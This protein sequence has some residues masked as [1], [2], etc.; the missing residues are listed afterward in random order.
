MVHPCMA[1]YVRMDN[2]YTDFNMDPRP[3]I[4][5]KGKPEWTTLYNHLLQVSEAADCFAN[6][7]GMNRRLARLGGLLHDV[8]KAHPDFQKRLNGVR[9]DYTYRHE[10]ASLFFL[11]L[12]DRTDWKPLTEMIIAHHK[13][14]ENDV[15]E[16]G[17][18][19]LLNVEDEGVRDRHLGEWDNWHQIGLEVLEAHGIVVRR[20]EVKEA[21]EAFDWVVQYSEEV[22]LQD[23]FN[24]WR[25]LLMGADHFASALLDETLSILPKMFKRP[26]LR[27]FE[28]K[29]KRFPLS[30]KAANSL[31]PHTMVVASTGAGKTDYLFRRC[32]G[33]VFY[34]LP[35][36]ASINAM[37]Y[38]LKD[39]LQRDNQDLELRMKHAASKL[40]A[41]S[42][43]DRSKK[44]DESI[45]S[46]FGASVKVLTP[47]QVA[48]I[49]L[50][51]K[52]YEAILLD[53]RNCDVILDEVHTYNDKA[54]GI[55]LKLIE[56]LVS[57]NCRI[58]IGTATMPTTL[59]SAIREQL[60]PERT[61]EVRL[62]PD[63]LDQYNRH[64]VIKDPN[65]CVDS[66]D[67]LRA[68]SYLEQ[69]EVATAMA[70][71][72]KVLFI[73]NQVRHAQD[74]YREVKNKY[75]GVPSLLLHSRFKRGDRAKLESKLLGLDYEGNETGTFNTSTDACIVV[76]TQV[77]E[78]SIDISFDV[79]V[80]ACAPLD[81]LIQRFGRI[82]RK[83]LFKRRPVIVL[84]PPENDGPALP[85]ELD[86]LRQ[87]YT[88]L[89]DG[90]LHEQDLQGLLDT[91][92][93]D[94]VLYNINEISPYKDGKWTIG[95]LINQNER[96]VDFLE[97]DSATCI[98]DSDIKEYRE[99]RGSD[100]MP[101][102]FS[103]RY[104]TVQ[105]CPR[106]EYGSE[107][108]VIAAAA[109]DSEMGVDTALIHEIENCL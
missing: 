87:T 52:G 38:R 76:S 62:S 101:L 88:N 64:T 47:F 5:A 54:Q 16:K 83:R 6:Y 55:V 61:L 79:M 103:L 33:R 12:F 50:A 109:Y 92:Y 8:G 45:Q 69:A 26:N 60:E 4:K 70:A 77:V 1:V 9:L 7:L 100:R 34:M 71:G 67:N 91:V 30:L 53:M 3:D 74:L 29:S 39:F 23:G 35:F 58:H 48:A 15:R 105:D 86:V 20:I 18:L 99:A 95:Q 32:R 17:L 94:V 97:I 80:T 10:I 24:Q 75:P 106:L 44:A 22:S 68:E 73:C 82:N 37:Y 19:D 42:R 96:L 51:N 13:S 14:V 11:P 59:F 90:D 25:G 27:A 72:Q 93:P 49:A 31:R 2:P 78:V 43:T 40:H 85:Y 57:I 41:E 28:R 108:F 66:E 107:P 63:E 65:S 21:C 36:Q 89:P 84:A 81:A 102:E 46:L 104:W 56:V 98:L